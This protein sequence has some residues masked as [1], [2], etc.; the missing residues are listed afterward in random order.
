MAGSTETAVLRAVR[1]DIL[2]IG[3]PLRKHRVQV[4]PDIFAKACELLTKGMTLATVVVEVDGRKHTR[5]VL[6]VH[7]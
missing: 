6:D 2:V 7:G 3:T 4:S 5:K 1:P